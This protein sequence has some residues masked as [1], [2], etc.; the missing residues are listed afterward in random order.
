MRRAIQNNTDKHQF[1]EL[2]QAGEQAV[3][4][5][6]IERLRIVVAH[7]SMIQIGGGSIDASFEAA[8][9]IRG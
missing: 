1:A 9:I 3:R 7:L 2:M 4:S 8:N 5:D 6:D